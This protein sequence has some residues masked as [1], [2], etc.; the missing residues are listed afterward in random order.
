MT[1]AYHHIADI[2]RDHALKADE[3]QWIV[4]KVRT[5]HP[6]KPIFYTTGGREQLLKLLHRYQ[7]D[8]DIVGL[9]EIESLP[10]D[11]DR[12]MERRRELREMMKPT[13]DDT[14]RLI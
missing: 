1:Q 12:R 11:E 4:M 14:R 10:S 9:A 2:N 8:P 3:L 7:I 5:P 6:D 13:T